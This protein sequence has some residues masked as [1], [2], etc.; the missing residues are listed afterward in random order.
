MTD[1]FNAIPDAWADELAYLANQARRRSSRVVAASPLERVLRDRLVLIHECL[2]EF[3]LDLNPR[4]TRWALGRYY[5]SRRFLRVYIHDRDA[6]PR[7][8]EEVFA[9]FLHE[10]A[11]HL[12]ATEPHS[13]PPAR[14]RPLPR[15]TRRGSHG[16]R[17]RRILKTLEEGWEA[18]RTS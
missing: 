9:I 17:F 16:P 4:P 13:F 15:S 11:H 10:V 18:A 3:E 12:D 14:S 2:V 1:T 5:R 7:P 8:L 6:G